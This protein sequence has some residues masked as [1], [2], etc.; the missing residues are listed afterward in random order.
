MPTDSSSEEYNSNGNLKGRFREKYVR[1]AKAAADKVKDV[2][3]DA[4]TGSP[5]GTA[6][7]R[8]VEREREER[9]RGLIKTAM[10]LRA[11][12]PY[13]SLGGSRRGSP[14]DP[15]YKAIC[16]RQTL[17]HIEGIGRRRSLMPDEHQLQ[18]ACHQDLDLEIREGRA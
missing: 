9:D 1:E 11:R 14:D 18:E 6:A 2:A 17:A 15:S 10:M 7:A 3:E 5:P 12:P 8:R 4:A 13:F 16:A